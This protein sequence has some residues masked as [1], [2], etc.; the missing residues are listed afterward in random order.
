MK[1]LTTRLTTLTG[2]LAA[3]TVL[4]VALIGDYFEP[5][6]SHRLDYLSELNDADSRH[7]LLI[8][9]LGWLPAG[10]LTLLF[11]WRLR[12][13]IAPGARSAVG[14]IF[15]ALI[16]TD[17]FVT[18][19]APCDAGCPAYGAMSLSQQIHNVSG[20]LSGLL[21]PI[22]IY[23]LIKPLRAAGFSRA[24]IC[25]SYLAIAILVGSFAVMVAG[26]FGHAIGIVQRV[27][28]ASYYGYLALLS[29]EIYR[30]TMSHAQPVVS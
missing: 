19:F 26:V 5:S 6:F 25:M 2:V 14:L 23:L 17:L 10:V 16:G 24:A 29:I 9:Y 8:G 12:R 4:A 27:S 28:I 30:R 20:G 22:G 15:I 11:I 13:E 21:V 1:K 7:P 18:H 3:V